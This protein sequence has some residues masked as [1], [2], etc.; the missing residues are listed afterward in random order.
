MAGVWGVWG[1]TG[2]PGDD[3]VDIE[4]AATIGGTLESCRLDEVDDRC[5]SVDDD[6]DS[7]KALFDSRID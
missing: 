6:I 2:F 4:V 7:V 5:N 3:D 1:E